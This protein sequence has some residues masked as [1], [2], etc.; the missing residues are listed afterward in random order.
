MNVFRPA[1]EPFCPACFLVL[2]HG[3]QLLLSFGCWTIKS[4]SQGR[5]LCCIIPFISLTAPKLPTEPQS[6]MLEPPMLTFQFRPGMYFCC[7][8]VSQSHIPYLG[9]DPVAV[10]DHPNYDE[11]VA[12]GIILNFPFWCSPNSQSGKSMSC[13]RIKILGRMAKIQN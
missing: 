4:Y 3:S 9:L 13:D 12:S 7:I 10:L 1:F 8:S 11:V 6:L 2:L 5:F